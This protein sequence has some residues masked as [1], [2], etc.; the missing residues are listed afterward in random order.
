M[1]AITLNGSKVNLER[2]KVLRQTKTQKKQMKLT[3]PIY[4]YNT[5]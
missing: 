3:K 5:F 4:S 1:L 2:L